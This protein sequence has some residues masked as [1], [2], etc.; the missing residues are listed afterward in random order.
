M[1]PSSSKRVVLASV[2]KPV[3]DTRMVEKMAVSLTRDGRF[4][5]T[6]IGYG[7]SENAMPGISI[8]GLGEF[9]RVSVARLLAPLQVLVKCY[10]VKPEILIV[11]THELL[12]VGLANRILFG[13]EIWYDLQENYYRNIRF[14]G[15]FPRLVR[16]PLALFVRAKEK[17]LAPFFKGFFLAEKGYEL[18]LTFLGNRALVLENKVTRTTV[19]PRKKGAH[20]TFLFS[21]TLAESTGVFDAIRL[22][23]AIRDQGA[24]VRLRIIGYAALQDVRERL[25]L[26]S[27]TAPF[28]SLEGIDRLVPH[29]QIM[30]AIAEA[31]AGIIAYPDSPHTTHS[32]PTKLYE[33]LGNQLPIVCVNHPAWCELIEKWQAGVCIDF[34]NFQASEVWQRLATGRFY[35]TPPTDVFWEDEEPRFIRALADQVG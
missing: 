35:P 28:V 21:G 29:R 23:R 7:K 31:D 22:V 15:V 24:E 4:A 33:Y 25:M 26:A 2:L 19:I 3:D 11:N 30:A 27:S 17:L 5:V 1:P 8:Y 34:K 6:V 10:Q 16:T 13:T 32:I 14:G 9:K 20:F 18:E 12:V